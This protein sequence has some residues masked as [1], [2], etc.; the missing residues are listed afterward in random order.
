MNHSDPLSPRPRANFDNVA[1]LDADD[2]QDLATKITGPTLTPHDEQYDVERTGNQT[3]RMHRPAIIVG[4]TGAPDVQTAIAFARDRGL[5]VAV[6]GTGH[7]SAAVA[8]HD[9]MLINTTRM[10]GFRLDEHASSAWVSAGTRWDQ[11]LDDAATVGLAPLSGSAPHIAAVPYTLGGGL[12][13]LSRRYGYAADHVRSL[14]VVTADGNLQ[15]VTSS[16][17]P[18]LF[19][20]LRGGRDNFGVVTA[21]EIGLVPVTSLYGGGLF[22]PATSAATVFETYVQWTATVPDEMSS[23]IALI[24]YPD[25]PALPEQLRGRHIVHLRIAYLGNLDR[26]TSLVAPLRA[27]G[28]LIDTVAPIPYTKAGSV[29]NDPAMPGSFEAETAMLGERGNSAVHALLEVAGPHAQVPHVV[30]IRH[31]GGQLARL[32]ATANAVGHRHARYVINVI[33]RLERADISEIRPAHKRVLDAIN[34][35]VTT[36]RSLNFMNGN[37]A[38]VHTPAAYSPADYQRLRELKAIYDPHNM[39]RHNHNIPPSPPHGGRSTE[40]TPRARGLAPQ[41][42]W[43]DRCDNGHP[44]E[45]A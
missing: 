17:E 31:L 40:R 39:F 21:M 3:A 14:D 43:S 5:A 12:G 44:R 42:H 25:A 8:A 33:S 34:R 29:H 32:P 13:L 27:L 30:E 24:S 11:I 23:S 37:G 28:P 15:R 16:T 20:A 10:K 36:G 22:F 18:D 19:W 26:G 4:A 45:R 38:A 9:G 7:A 2:V 35:W 6:Q 1:T 41:A